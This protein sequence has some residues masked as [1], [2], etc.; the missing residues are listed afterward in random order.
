MG[1]HH[2]SKCDNLQKLDIKLDTSEDGFWFVYHKDLKNSARIQA[3]FGF[4][5]QSL[6]KS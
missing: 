5:E 2:V 4:L 6:G 3:L 1:I